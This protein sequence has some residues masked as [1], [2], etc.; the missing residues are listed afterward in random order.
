MSTKL[1][2]VAEDTVPAKKSVNPVIR[3]FQNE[4]KQ[5]RSL[6][7]DC[8]KLVI[9]NF[10]Y[11][12]INAMMVIIANSYIWR[13]SGDVLL[14]MSYW[15]GYYAGVSTGFFFTGVLLRYIKVNY[16]YLAGMLLNSLSFLPIVFVGGTIT[17]P[18][19]LTTGIFMGIGGGMYW[20]NR[21]YMTV[22]STHNN[23]RNYMGGI[24][25]SLMTVAQIIGPALFGA[26]TTTKSTAAGANQKGYEW[27]FVI[28]ALL[29]IGAGSF[30]IKGKYKEIRLKKFVYLKYGS[31]WNRQ[32]LVNIFEGLAEGSLFTVPS[33]LILRKVGGEGSLG[34][35]ESVAVV[36]STV[37]VYL[38]GRYAKPQHRIYLLALSISS[39]FIGSAIVAASYTA[40]GVIIFYAFNK[41]A[42]IMNAFIYAAIRLRSIDVSKEKEGRDEYAYIFD[43]DVFTEIGRLASIGFFCLVYFEFDQD[44]ALRYVLFIVSAVQFGAVF[45]ARKLKQV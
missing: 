20:S 12:I 31:V 6:S 44:V 40:L 26:L 17:L 25:Y 45:F 28:L 15:L 14:N 1:T 19:L 11:M 22:V 13:Q 18:I 2:V 3:Y 10:L 30:I 32:R 42:Y 43:A 34:I 37:P 36:M 41:L 27:L 4:A 5:F 29:A 8:R 38:L 9:A 16:L 7:A 33:I 21:H 24:E 35:I 39:F 23:D